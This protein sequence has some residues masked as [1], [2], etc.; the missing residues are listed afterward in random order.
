[1]VL[2]RQSCNPSWN[3]NATSA[4]PTSQG[5]PDGVCGCSLSLCS[6]IAIANLGLLRILRS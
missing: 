4:S 3:L 5:G 1:M 6:V 2:A